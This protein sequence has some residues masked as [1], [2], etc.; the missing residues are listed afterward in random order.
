MVDKEKL[1][2]ALKDCFDPELQID[3]WTLGLIYELKVSDGGKVD[4]RMT[5]TTPFC[6]YG[7]ALMEEVEGKLRAVEGVKE[8][9]IEL[10]FEPPW[11]PSD[12]LRAMLGI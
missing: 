4:A 2:A 7:P 5:L 8:V 3:V 10:V 11:Q 12:E 9:H 1:I 6:P